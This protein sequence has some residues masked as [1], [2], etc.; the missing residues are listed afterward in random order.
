MKTFPTPGPIAA[1]IEIGAGDI[2]INASDRTD[3]TITIR[4]R[5][6]AKP[7]DVRAAEIALVDFANN[8]LTLKSVKTWRRFT[9]PMKNDGSVVVEVNLPSGSSLTAST[10]IGLVHCEGELADT[11]AK[12]GMGDIRLD[13]VGAL[14]ARTGL[15]DIAVD[16]I[17]GNAKVSTSTGALRLGTIQGS[18]VIKN[19]NGTVEVAEC[20]RDT[21]IRTASGDIAIGRA[22]ASVSAGSAAGD[23]RISEVSN[24]SVTI[25]S[26]A[27][28][29]EIGVRE[30]AAAWLEVASRY[31]SVRNGLT[32]APGPDAADSTVAVRART[33]AGDITITRAAAAA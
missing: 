7:D 23:I 12:T 28:A 4:P 1:F 11:F 17:A 32:T 2:K 6:E 22:L 9:G 18:A 26:G 27:G 5:N 21:H 30:G 33:G 14:Q 19:S 31:G 3:C 16:S 20:G 24:G 13:R 15:G 8:T 10:G 29:I 25:R